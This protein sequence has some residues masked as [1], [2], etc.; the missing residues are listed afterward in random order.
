[1]NNSKAEVR[2]NIKVCSILFRI[3]SVPLYALLNSMKDID[4]MEWM[5]QIETHS[6]HL[7]KNQ[8]VSSETV[9][10]SSQSVPL[11]NYVSVTCSRCL[12]CSHYPLSY[13]AYTLSQEA[14]T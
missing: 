4:V 11:Q 9:T 7:G 14:A 8:L 2:L 13:R 6:K 10:K 12:R 3:Q 1:M 5:E